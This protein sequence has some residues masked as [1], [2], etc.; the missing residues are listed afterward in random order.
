MTPWLRG[1]RTTLPVFRPRL[2]PDPDELGVKLW[3]NAFRSGDYVGRH[4]WRTDPCEYLWWAHVGGCSG[5]PP[6]EYHSTDGPP[7][8]RIEFCI[9]AGAHTHYWDETG[10]L[11]TLELDR[12]IAS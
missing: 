3:V 1:K 6:Q 5:P 11:I 10:Q 7:P 12:L 2:A 4:L 8:S 9:G